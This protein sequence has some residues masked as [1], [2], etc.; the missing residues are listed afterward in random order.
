[1]QTTATNGGG[2][3]SYNSTS[4]LSVS[5]C[6]VTCKTATK[7]LCMLYTWK[8]MFMYLYI[9]ELITTVYGAAFI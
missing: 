2:R 4:C 6:P 7:L 8:Y 5:L 9:A 1:M 3:G